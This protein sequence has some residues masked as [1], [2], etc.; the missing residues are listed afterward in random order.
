MTRLRELEAS[1]TAVYD[2]IATLTHC[3]PEGFPGLDQLGYKPTDEAE[4]AAIV[5]A[6][7][8]GTARAN[9]EVLDRLEGILDGM[10]M[11]GAI[12]ATSL[13]NRFSRTYR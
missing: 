1:E 9:G 3:F 2:L 6:C 11:V 10:H 13:K 8:C 12:N 4:K 7:R 5:L